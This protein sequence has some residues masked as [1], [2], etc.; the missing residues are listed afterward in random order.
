MGTLAE[1]AFR[2]QALRRAWEDVLAADLAD[3]ALAPGVDRF[4][5]DLEDQLGRLQADLDWNAYRPQAL[6]EVRLAGTVA[7]AACRSRL[8][9]TGSS[10]GQSCRS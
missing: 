1:L 2:P 6:T 10:R 4:Q 8:S 3:G 7:A 9:E 5:N